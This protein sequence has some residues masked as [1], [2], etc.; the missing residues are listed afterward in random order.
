DAG[1]CRQ[2]CRHALEHA[3]V[4]APDR[5]DPALLARLDAVAGRV[6]SR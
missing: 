6:L 2:G 4:T 3:L 5:R 1:P